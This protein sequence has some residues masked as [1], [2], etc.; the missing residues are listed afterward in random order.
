MNK[1]TRTD[2]S[3][4]SLKWAD[5]SLSLPLRLRIVT[6]EG[7][8]NVCP[9][10]LPLVVSAAVMASVFQW[11][12]TAGTSCIQQRNSHWGEWESR[13]TLKVSCLKLKNG[14][15]LTCK[16]DRAIQTIF[17]STSYEAIQLSTPE[18][19]MAESHSKPVNGF[20]AK[21]NRAWP[22]PVRYDKCIVHATLNKCTGSVPKQKQGLIA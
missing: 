20:I 12:Q 17:F 19:S 11:V 9:L 3:I 10:V 16:S 15:M 7:F 2:I 1:Q 4:N 8:G 21:P 13:Q 22:D 14:M 5:L 6:S 18:N